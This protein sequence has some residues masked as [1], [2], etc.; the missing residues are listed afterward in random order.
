MAEHIFN[1]EAAVTECT[2]YGG[3]EKG[4]V[5]RS[6]QQNSFISEAL[7]FSLKKRKRKIRKKK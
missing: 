4:I 2:T 1:Q 7:S 3:T 6:A 5:L